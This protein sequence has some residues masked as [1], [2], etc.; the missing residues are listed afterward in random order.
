LPQRSLAVAIER[1]CGGVSVWGVHG[2]ADVHKR[3]G[4]GHPKKGGGCRG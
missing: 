4:D 1:S 2:G 3:D